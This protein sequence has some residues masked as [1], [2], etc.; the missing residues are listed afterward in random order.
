MVSAE[1]W[2]GD[3]NDLSTDEFKENFGGKTLTPSNIYA[4][5]ETLNHPIF[6]PVVIVKWYNEKP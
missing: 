2:V 1:W 6:A 5:I 3:G 4:D